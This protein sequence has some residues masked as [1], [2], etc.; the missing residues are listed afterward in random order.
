MNVTH[1]PI[2]PVAGSEDPVRL[3]VSGPVHLHLHLGHAP[4]APA[5]PP[6]AQQR[7]IFGMALAGFLLV[8]GGYWFGAH[9]PVADAA[10]LVATGA[11]VPSAALPLPPGIAPLAGAGGDDVP[12]EA[13]RQLARLRQQLNQPAVV[14]PAPG[15]VAPQPPGAKGAPSTAA[16][17]AAAGAASLQH[18][19]NPFGLGE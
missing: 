18:R 19:R 12:P 17:A 9:R 6:V 1:T 15:G 7:S 4:A 10:D 3:E 16:P 14:T 2:P 8:G 13:R 5:A 11:A